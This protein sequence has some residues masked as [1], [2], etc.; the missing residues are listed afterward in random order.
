MPMPFD[1][2]RFSRWLAYVLRHNPDR[3]GL[4]LDRHGFTD[5][6]PFLL[7]AVRRSP[8]LTEERL[9]ELIAGPLS[10][11]FELAGNRL[12]ARYGHSVPVEPAG[13][14]VIPPDFLYHGTEPGR[15]DAILREGLK[16]VERRM[17]H[18]SD[19]LEEA[20]AVARR[21]TDQPRIVRVLAKEAHARGISFYHEGRVYLT[22]QIPPELL[23]LEARAPD[24]PWDSASESTP[25]QA[26]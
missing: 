12:R 3:Y 2:E 13:E 25:P 22:A 1:E 15:A 9:R 5:L 19:T 11:R 26:P 20:L 21:K 4:V 8:E 18:L 14:P 24:Q 6:E 7:I 23:T 17:L 16:P 10:Q